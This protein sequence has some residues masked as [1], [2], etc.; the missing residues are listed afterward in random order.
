[1]LARKIFKCKNA[2]IKIFATLA[3]CFKQSAVLMAKA[4]NDSPDISVKLSVLHCV[5]LTGQ[6]LSIAM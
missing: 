2:H 1:M 4:L 6:L 3:L 5:V